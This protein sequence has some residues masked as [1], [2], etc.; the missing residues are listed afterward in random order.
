MRLASPDDLA[1]S[2]VEKAG[3]PPPRKGALLALHVGSRPWLAD[4]LEQEPGGLERPAV[5]LE[6]TMGGSKVKFDPDANSWS[7]TFCP[8]VR[9]F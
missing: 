1:R 3:E 9:S 7:V 6:M 2:R 5:G 8:L 4:R